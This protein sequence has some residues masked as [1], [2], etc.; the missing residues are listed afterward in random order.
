M[1]DAA[2]IT[3]PDAGEAV[4]HR[5]DHNAMACTFEIYVAGHDAKYAGHAAAAAFA[6]VDRLEQLLSRFIPTSEIAQ[7]NALEPGHSLRA[8]LETI[9][10]L[11]IA[12]QLFADTAGAFDVAFR[13]ADRSAPPLILDPRQHAIGV[14]VANVQIDLGGLGKG[15]AVDQVVARLREWSIAAAV[16]HS[17]RSTAYALGSP[18]GAAGWRMSL[19][20]AEGAAT[21][22]TLTLR[23]RALSGS[24]QVLHGAHIVDPRTGQ[25]V[26]AGRCAWALA[27]SAAVAD[28]LSTA[29]M[30]LSDAEVADVCGRRADATAILS[31]AVSVGRDVVQHGAAHDLQR[32]SRTFPGER[33][34][35]DPR[36]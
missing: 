33:A 13:R 29:F 28:G 27:D 6:E 12:A 23:D 25:P 36:P 2:P 20:A 14:Q 19:R 7:L 3:F 24:G 8:S 17:G 16:V 9:E 18:P 5:F 4:L 21:L 31:T 34:A 15:Y 22:G 1:S 26:P 11:Q 10:C 35:Q 32:D 30:I